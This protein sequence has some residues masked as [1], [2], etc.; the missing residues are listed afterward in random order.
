MDFSFKPKS[1]LMTFPG[2]L[3]ITELFDSRCFRLAS[4]LPESKPNLNNSHSD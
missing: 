1:I 3:S 2:K 4:V